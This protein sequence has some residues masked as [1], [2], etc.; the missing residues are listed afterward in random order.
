MLHRPLQKVTV[1]LQWPCE[2]KEEGEAFKKVDA[3]RFAAAAA[4][5]QL[6]V[7]KLM[8]TNDTVF[9]W[10]CDSWKHADTFQKMGII[11]PND[12]LPRRRHGR[13]TYRGALNSVLQMQNKHVFAAKTTD[14]GQHLPLEGDASK[15]YEALSLFPQPKSLLTRVIQA[16]T[17]ANRIKV[18]C[19]HLYFLD[20]L[21]LVLWKII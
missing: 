15:I 14:Q 12:Q 17:S 21:C 8:K 3:E 13:Q 11:G 16:A 7:S 1:M 19:V 4:C 2:I 10:Y 9:L 18:C 5:L 20:K 6:R